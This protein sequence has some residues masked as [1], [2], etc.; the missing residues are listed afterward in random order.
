MRFCFR[1]PLYRIKL[2][3]FDL[4]SPINWPVI[5]S[6]EFVT[7]KSTSGIPAFTYER[8]E[9]LPL[10]KVSSQEG[11]KNNERIEYLLSHR[12]AVLP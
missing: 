8:Y 6:V 12:A 9:G 3:W 1:L 10:K 2:A 4:P 5:Q 7:L 11:V